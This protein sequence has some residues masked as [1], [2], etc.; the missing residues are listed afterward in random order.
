MKNL[1]N[2]LTNNEKDYE[3]GLNKLLKRGY[4]LIAVVLLLVM[5]C[6]CTQQYKEIA[7][8]IGTP[9]FVVA[10]FWWA[11][12]LYIVITAEEEQ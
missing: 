8:I 11:I 3:K 5:V 7:T 9:F 6:I 4:T 10:L 12:S 2:L 1:Y